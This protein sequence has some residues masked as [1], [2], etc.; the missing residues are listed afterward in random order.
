MWSCRPLVSS[1]SVLLRARLAS[2][3]LCVR[4]AVAAVSPTAGLALTSS[5]R[6]DS[7]WLGTKAYR[8]GRT[9]RSR[10]IFFSSIPVPRV[11]PARMGSRRGGPSGQ[12]V[13]S[14]E[15][16]SSA[17]PAS[18]AICNPSPE[19][20]SAQPIGQSYSLRAG[21]PPE[22]VSFSESKLASPAVALRLLVLVLDGGICRRRDTGWRVRTC[23]ARSSGKSPT[24]ALARGY[25]LPALPVSHSAVLWP[26]KKK[27]AAR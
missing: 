27:R 20:K 4:C 25:K 10:G 3:C 26:Q 21:E 7:L 18:W 17:P 15:L 9:R 11:P 2:F 5:A 14:Q 23:S 24:K 6:P 16:R 1:V 12:W 22:G 13:L 8:Q 19:P